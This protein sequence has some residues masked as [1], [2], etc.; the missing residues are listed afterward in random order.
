LLLQSRGFRDQLGRVGLSRLRHG[1]RI[2]VRAEASKENASLG[3]KEAVELKSETA[4]GETQAAQSAAQAKAPVASQPYVYYD[5]FKKVR[6]VLEL[7]EGK[8]I[9][10]WPGY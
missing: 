3:A 8:A 7:W 1:V 5:K 6:G 10:K 4:P 2:T 9:G